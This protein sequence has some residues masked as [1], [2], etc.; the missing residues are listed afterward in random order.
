MFN[1]DTIYL[2]FV[3]MTFAVSQGFQPWRIF[4]KIS[5]YTFKP[6]TIEVGCVIREHWRDMGN[7]Y[8]RSAPYYPLLN[9]QQL[10]TQSSAL[11][12]NQT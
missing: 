8:V 7:T 5:C 11:A 6:I 10:S 2:V 1:C 12:N 3:A 9:A 4:L